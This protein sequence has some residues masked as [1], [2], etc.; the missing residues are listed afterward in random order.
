L[1]VAE[2]TVELHLTHAYQELEITSRASSP[3][4]FDRDPYEHQMM[5]GNILLIE[6]VHRTSIS[7]AEPGSGAEQL[8]DYGA[9][10]GSAFA[11]LKAC[12][13]SIDSS[14]PS[15]AAVYDGP[16]PSLVFTTREHSIASISPHF[17]ETSAALPGHV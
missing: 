10:S 3:L 13:T 5:R 9:S 16:D 6:V 12:T 7:K 8:S 15:T 14:P 17:L 11:E 4:P 2:R 1:F